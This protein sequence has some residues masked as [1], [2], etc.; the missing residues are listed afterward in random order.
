MGQYTSVLLA[1]FVDNF[2]ENTQVGVVGTL[3]KGVENDCHFVQFERVFYHHT[4]EFVDTV[5]EEE[6]LSLLRIRVEEFVRDCA[7]RFNH[8]MKQVI[9]D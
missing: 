2:V 8:Q 9:T 4:H 7:K 3:Y 1:K 6:Q 5:F